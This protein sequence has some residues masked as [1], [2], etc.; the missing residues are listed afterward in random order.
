M[1]D[2]IKSLIYVLV[3]SAPAF[4]IGRR[5]TASLISP[6]EFSVW[7]NAWFAATISAFLFNSLF[8]VFVAVVVLICVYARAAHAAT[9]ALFIV[10]LLAV[11]LVDIT[12]S[13]FG[14]VGTILVI[15][16]GRLLA[17]ILLLPILLGTRKPVHRNGGNYAMPDWLAVGYV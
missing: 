6:R 8:I 14:M 4:Y 9:V 7:R 12:I 2:N 16:N 5:V 13:G 10:L 3:L 1:P 15:N 17:I 11:P